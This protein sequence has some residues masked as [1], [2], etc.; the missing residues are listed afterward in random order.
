MDGRPTARRPRAGLI[1][2]RSAGGLVALLLLASACA[3]GAPRATPRIVPFPT[4]GARPV[5]HIQGIFTDDVAL[6]TIANVFARDFGFPPLTASVVF[7]PSRQSL[8]QE[9]LTAGYDPTF[10]RDASDRMRAV[11]LHRRVLINS[12]VLSTSTWTARVGTLAHELV[13]CLQYELAGG[14]RGTSE[15]WLREGFAEWIA[16]DLLRR[17]DGIRPGA[18]RRYL[19][20]EFG[21]SRRAEAPRFDDMMTFRQWVD[22]AGRP[23]IVPQVQ[24]VL[25]VDL[26]I[27]RHGVPAVLDYFT[28]FAEREDPV[29]NFAA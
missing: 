16:L 28:R 8:E 4:T 13:H 7:L 11:A 26:L 19:E 29:G 17:I 1:A 10:A 3:S 14:R 22:L 18:A 24:A 5:D 21:A 12:T 27:E 20:D 23:R 2:P 25:T 6:A 9:L 15:Q